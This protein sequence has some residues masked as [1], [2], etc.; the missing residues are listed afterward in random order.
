[1]KPLLNLVLVFV[2]ATP[3]A[4]AASMPDQ[5][6]KGVTSSTSF[7]RV[8]GSYFGGGSQITVICD[9]KAVATEKYDSDNSATLGFS[10][11]TS[12]IVNKGLRVATCTY[13]EPN[14][15]NYSS[16]LCYLARQ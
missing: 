12:L 13:K 6:N 5:I 8:F 7:C 1:M 4:S 2:A 15:Y 14:E 16:E 3:V 9:G 10:Q 11:T